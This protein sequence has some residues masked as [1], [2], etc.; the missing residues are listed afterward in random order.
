MH[1]VSGSISLAVRR[2]FHL[3]LT[4][5]F[6]IGHRLVFSLGRWSSRIQPGF[7]VSRPTRGPHR[8]AYSHFAYGTL[9]L[10][11]R[12]FQYR[13]AML[14]SRLMIR[15]HNPRPG[16]PVRVW[17]L[18]FS[19]AATLGISIDFF[20]SRYLDVSVPW[21][22][23]LTGDGIA[24]AGF[25]HSDTPGSMLAC[26]SPRLFAAC[27]VLHRRSVPRHPPCALVRLTSPLP[28]AGRGWS[29]CLHPCPAQS[30]GPVH[31][32]L[33]FPTRTLRRVHCGRAPRGVACRRGRLE[34]P[35]ALSF[36][37]PLFSRS[38]VFAAPGPAPDGPR[39][40]AGWG[41]REANSYER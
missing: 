38:G 2:S 14:S 32:R 27:H 33:A 3:S 22:G 17:A 13:S 35:K 39:T 19:L 37:L 10:Y 8:L 36:L 25:P 23:S 24:P 18:P 20:S 30:F 21:V 6:T 34:R 15:P 9:T 11:G 12:T 29:S 7:H 40:E 5:L 28:S 4:V 16:H 26:S 41:R 1:T 31:H